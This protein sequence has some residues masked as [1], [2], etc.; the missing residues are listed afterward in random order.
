M[1]VVFGF[2]K[3]MNIDHISTQISFLQDLEQTDPEAA[4]AGAEQ[5]RIGVLAAIAAGAENPKEL[6]EAVMRTVDE[7]IGGT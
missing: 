1:R 4:E 7:D 3:I 5:L 2:S 6:A